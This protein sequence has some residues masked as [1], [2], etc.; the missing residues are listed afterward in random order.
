MSPSVFKTSWGFIYSLLRYV[1][2]VLWVNMNQNIVLPIKDKSLLWLICMNVYKNYR[3]ILLLASFHFYLNEGFYF[4]THHYFWLLYFELEKTKVSNI[5][6]VFH[7]DMY[8]FKLLCGGW[9]CFHTSFGFWPRLLRGWILC[10]VS[11]APQQHANLDVYSL[12]EIKQHCNVTGVG[13][14]LVE[15]GAGIAQ[16]WVMPDPR[17][18]VWLQEVS[19]PS[20]QAE[21]KSKASDVSDLR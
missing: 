2:W 5:Q 10:H 18:D 1:S 9:V 15:A 19:E 3:K 6:L 12:Q 16:R 21:V 11:V 17:T 8:T 20:D 13:W 7:L 14:S 4:Q